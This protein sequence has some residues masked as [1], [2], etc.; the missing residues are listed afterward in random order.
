MKVNKEILL[1]ERN[2]KKIKF[3][4]KVTP[5]TVV[6]Y[7]MYL[8]WDKHIVHAAVEYSINPAHE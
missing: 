5:S 8:Q 1:I 6:V 3:D 4:I 7:F 2:N